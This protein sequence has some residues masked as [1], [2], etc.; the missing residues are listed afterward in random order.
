MKN[1]D[2]LVTWYLESPIYGDGAYFSHY[3]SN[4]RGP[5]YPEITAYAISLSC[6][7]YKKRQD[8]R[9]LSRAIDCAE[10]MM[11]ISRN[12]GIPSLSD[13][14]LY[15]FD[16]GI[17]I[18]SMFDLYALTQN[19][20]YL[21]EAKK[22]LNWLDS[23]WNGGLSAV[24]KIPKNKAW[25][26]LSSAHLLKLVIPLLKASTCLKD[27]KYE[28]RALQL[29]GRYG[30]LQKEDGWFIVNETA[31]EVM[32]HPH[33]YATEGVLYA[34][35]VL[36]KKELLD[37]AKRASDW[38]CRMQNLDGSFY[39]RYD[40]DR[41][42]KPTVGQEKLKT[43]DVTA[44]ATRIWKLLG[45]NQEGIDRAYEY[46]NGELKGNGLRLF[47]STSVSG[48]LLSWRRAIYSWPTFFY[49]HSLTLPFGQ[50]EL[51]SE[52]F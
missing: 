31:S 39:R 28:N 36:Q 21:E 46:L 23:M 51:C 50:I 6:M 44:Q 17:Y 26:H 10:Y 18:S 16:T 9:F 24:D 20:A 4:S 2:K 14:L 22:S 40:V 45:T 48:R 37:S 35:H 47:K 3:S 8:Q 19:A 41:T 15:T 25:Y 27:Q 42:G 43:S 52:L 12:G 29:L 38:L 34:Y 30:H 13:N 5:I 32:T 1:L 49:L 33:C 11:R 7:L